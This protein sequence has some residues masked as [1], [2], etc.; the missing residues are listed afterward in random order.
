[1]TSHRHR[2]R[3]LGAAPVR[4]RGL[5]VRLLLAQSLVLVA[6]V[7]TC[8]VV[9]V[10]AGPPLF[11]EHLHRAGVPASSDEQFHAEQA[12]R[13]A[14]AISLAVALGVASLAALV[15]TWYFSRRLQRSVTEVSSAA[16]AVADGRYDI[17]VTSPHLGEDFDALAGAFNRMAAGLESVETTRR[18]LLGDLAHEIR[19]PVSVLEAY[20]EALEDGVETL[21]ADTIIMLRDQ[22]RR[23]VRFSDDVNALA[24]AEESRTSIEPT[25]VDPAA[26]L[27]TALTAAAD[28]YA[29]KEVALNSRVPARLPRLWADPE[30][31][32]QVLGNLLDNALR[33]TPGGGRVE[34]T[35]GQRH[36]LLVIEVT[37]T[38]DGI[39]SEH[40]P[41][42]FERFYR[43]DAARDRAHGG[44]G[45]GLAIAKALVEAQRG[46]IT[47]RSDGAGTGSTFTI[48]LPLR[49]DQR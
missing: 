47:A 36:E 34:V 24:H 1:M 30:R 19:T 43:V 28:R 27:S 45:I 5:G 41:H 25:W 12:Y 37:D 11:R 4:G 23:L 21:D 16:T 22:T 9:A 39:A 15:V 31:L 32:G 35:A 20:M 33:H 6:G 14:T 3:T 10:F 2:P 7:A 26:L 8:W 49:R 29:A 13:S 44:A 18:Q 17:R 48:T 42:L 40:L 38:G 46:H